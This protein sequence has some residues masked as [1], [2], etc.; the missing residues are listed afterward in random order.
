MLAQKLENG[1]TLIVNNKIMDKDGD[2]PYDAQKGRTLN[3]MLAYG[4]WEIAPVNETPVGVE[5]VVDNPPPANPDQAA[6]AAP[7]PTEE[8]K[9]EVQPAKEEENEVEAPKPTPRQ[10]RPRRTTAPQAKNK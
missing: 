5:E 6:E 4:P 9:A 3:A 7:A 2:P 8:A 10:G 1:Y